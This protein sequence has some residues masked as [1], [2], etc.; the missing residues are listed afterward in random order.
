MAARGRTGVGPAPEARTSERT[1]G[2]DGDLPFPRPLLFT[3]QDV[4]RFCEVDLKTIHHWADAGK[5]PH[6]R[7]AGRHLRF[8]RNHLLHFLRAHGYPLHDAITSARPRLFLTDRASSV[9]IAADDLARRLAGRFA[10][11]RF[12]HAAAA[13]A[14]L[15]ADEPDVVIGSLEDPSW[16]GVATI[17][18]LK[19][20][21]LTS[22][23]VFVLVGSE[24]PAREDADLVLARREV[25]RLPAELARILAVA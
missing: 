15:V 14:H 8:R 12:P 11:R 13:I 21:A 19:A 16:A 24:A 18:A 17:A 1:A 9:D 10:V 5:I 3:A 2:A 6:H 25:G 7:T 22:W 23:P 4:A 20:D